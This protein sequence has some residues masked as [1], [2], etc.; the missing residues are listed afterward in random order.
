MGSDFER[1]LGSIGRLKIL[2]CLMES[3]RDDESF[4][5]YRLKTLTGICPHDLKKHLQ[6]LVELGLVRKIEQGSQTRYMVE[7]WNPIITSLAQVLKAFKPRE[8]K[9]RD[10]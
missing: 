5:I 6:V 2:R 8:S 4:S 10:G 9:G 7:K 3:L 1:S